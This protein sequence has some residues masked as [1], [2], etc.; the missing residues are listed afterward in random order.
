VR[1]FLLDKLN[2]SIDLCYSFAEL[3][4]GNQAVDRVRGQNV[5]KTGPTLD[6]L[7][8]SSHLFTCDLPL[9]WISYVQK[10]LSPQ[11]IGS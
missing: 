11:K 1:A 10:K 9:I 3:F 2:R 7:G 8:T 4:G 6:Y 5:P